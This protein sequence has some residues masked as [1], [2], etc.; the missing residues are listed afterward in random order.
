MEF[1]SG[2]RRNCPVGVSTRRSSEHFSVIAEPGEH[3]EGT[4]F[5]GAPQNTVRWHT[6]EG[7]FG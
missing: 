1:T 4:V 2:Q 3:V 7:N 6:G 5:V